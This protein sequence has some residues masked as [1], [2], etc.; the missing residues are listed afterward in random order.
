MPGC[1]VEMKKEIACAIPREVVEFLTQCK[2]RF[3]P[4]YALKVVWNDDD[5]R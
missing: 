4:A 1:S 2:D 3:G 5:A